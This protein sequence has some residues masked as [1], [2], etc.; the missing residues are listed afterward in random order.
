MVY[1]IRKCKSEIK[2]N[3]NSIYNSILELYDNGIKKYNIKT[4]IGK[5]SVSNVYL[6]ENILDNKEYVIKISIDNCDYILEELEYIYE[7]FNKNNIKS[8]CMPIYCGYILNM[9][10]YYIIYP[11]FGRYTIENIKLFNLNN[12]DKIDIIFQILN[13]LI[14]FTNC[15]HCDLKPSNIVLDDNKK[16]TIIDYGL[17]KD[18]SYIENILSTSYI[19]SPESL[20]SLDNL[21][22][23]IDKDD[24]IDYSKHDYYGLFFVILTILLDINFYKI[25]YNYLINIVKAQN[26]IHNPYLYIYCWYKFYYNSID[27]IEIKSLK[28]LIIYILTKY[29]KFLSMNFYNFNIF[30]NIYI[31]IQDKYIKEFIYN[32]I[33]FNYTKR[34]LLINNLIVKKIS[35]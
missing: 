2:L 30:Y 11:Y 18:L 29:P 17:I 13:Q 6:L 12:D 4:K 28:N 31:N 26:Y 33:H 7:I 23:L 32:L 25:F 8:E 9:N 24:Y 14:K 16:I 15:I 10:R 19:T 35:I 27:E 22:K 1:N 21:K 5:G 3:G 34:Q 20:L